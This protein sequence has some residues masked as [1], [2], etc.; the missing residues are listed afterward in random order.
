[1]KQ[2][3]IVV[4]LASNKIFEEFFFSRGTCCDGCFYCF[5]ESCFIFCIENDLHKWLSLFVCPRK[6]K[7]MNRYDSVTTTTDT[8]CNPI[9]S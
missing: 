8:H 9:F 2:F 5:Y 7:R 4:F 1:M 6:K 3:M